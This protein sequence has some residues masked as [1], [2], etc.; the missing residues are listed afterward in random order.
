VI[1]NVITMVKAAKPNVAPA[2]P[3]STESAA[4]AYARVAAELDAVPA[5]R[6]GSFGFEVS[7]AVSTVLGAAARVAEL[8]PAMVKRLPEHPLE[9][10]DKLTDY[11][12][13]A[14]YAYLQSFAP[15]AASADRVRELLAEAAPLRQRLLPVAEM[16]A[17]LGLVDASRIAE[18][19]AGT[20]HVDTAND[21]IALA[22]IFSNDWAKLSNQVPIKES[23]LDRAA[24]LGTELLVA[25]GV[26]NLGAANEPDAKGWAA[27]K[28]RAL[29]LMV[30]AYDDARQAVTYLRW[31]EG[32]VDSYTPSL[33]AHRRRAS[34]P[35]GTPTSRPAEP[36]PAGNETDEAP[37]T[38]AD[39]P[40]PKPR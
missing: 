27:R 34:R 30:D 25:L 17:A 22:A 16:L 5:E 32:D 19:R 39:D 1:V 35:A 8:R 21:L 9:G 36:T 3:A 37:T 14:Q 26:R 23:E 12:L 4:A 11:A 15:Q 29:R 38:P 20:G 18:I 31:K 40:S 13:A 28:N 7:T 10:I 33:F 2:R 6:V 24:V